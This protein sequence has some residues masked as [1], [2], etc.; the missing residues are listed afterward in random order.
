MRVDLLSIHGLGPGTNP[1]AIAEWRVGAILEAIAVRDAKS[2]QL[3]LDIGGQRHPARMAS[4]DGGD[5]ADGERMQ[6]RVLRNS[7]VLALETVATTKPNDV[8]ADANILPDALRRFVPRQQSPAPLLANL[9]WI[10]TGKNG[11]EALPKPV[12]QAVAQLWHAL[13]DVDDLF[14]PTTLESTLRR[15]GAF[16][17]SNLANHQGRPSATIASDLKALMLS[18]RHV[19][20]AQ[21]ARPAAASSDAAAHAPLPGRGP[22]TTLPALPATLSVI[23]AAPQQLNELARQTEG[24]LA[25]L[26][27]AQIANSAADPSLQS[28]L[29]ELPVRHDD[30]AAI[31]RLHVERD[32]SH[33]R[34]SGGADTWTV[35]AAVDLGQIGA[36]HAKVTLTGKRIGVQLRAESPIVVEVLASRAGELESMLRSAG[37]EIDRVLCLHGV[38]APE[39]IRQSRLLDVRA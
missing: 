11:S 9:A 13:P 16:L 23:D 7:P 2:G 15:S 34:S 36:L 21:D 6:L 31:L 39:I 26:T 24:A 14:D 35:E 20:A 28:I 27:T 3:W 10:A 5:P 8:R 19:L 1:G 4:S 22:L 37:L 38:P 30:R 17:E 29:I 12:M 25:R 32:S 33:R 18:L